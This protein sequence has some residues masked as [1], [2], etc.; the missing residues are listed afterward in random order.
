M[1]RPLLIFASHFLFI[2]SALGQDIRGGEILFSHVGGYVYA[3][4]VYLYTQTSI[5]INHATVLA[6]PG[7]AIMSPITGTSTNLPNDIT[8]WH[9]AFT[10]IYPGPGTFF[11]SVE[12]SFRV[13]GIQNIN[14]SSNEK[15]FLKSKM[16]I[17]PS[18]GL[19]SSPILLN[20]QTDVSISGGNFVHNPNA[21]DIDGDSLVYSLVATTS[22]NY[23]PPSGA[24]I[25]SITGDFQMPVSSVINAI[26]IRIDEWR[27]GHYIGST[28]RE[29]LIDSNTI[30]GITEHKSQEE[31][32]RIFPNPASNHFTLSLS[33]HKK[34]EVAITDITGKIIYS[35]TTTTQE[36]EISTKDFSEGVY[37]VQVKEEEFVET[38][39]VIVVQ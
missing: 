20:K 17:N 27:S 30:A 8:E 39:K 21:Y 25:N 18:L 15:I 5:G 14:G 13:A 36:L 33:N 37:I 23:S 1:K 7:D 9:Y 29:M 26:N 32:F 35:T 2:I 4:N 38:K 11:P 12:D 34:A 28:F 10:H 3:F 31:V 19:N 6:S 16:E 22:T 24:T